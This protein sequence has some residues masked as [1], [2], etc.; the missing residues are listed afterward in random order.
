MSTIQQTVDKAGYELGYIEYGAAL[1]ATDAADAMQALNE[2][3]AEWEEEDLNFNWF[4]Q[5]AL[6]DTLPIP[7]WAERCVIL[8][9]AIVLSSRFNVAP[10]QSLV[11]NARKSMT[12]ISTR[13]INEKLRKANMN[14]LPTGNGWGSRYDIDTDSF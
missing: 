12:T 9:L 8:N 6:S 11:D 1:D 14:H 5:D 3:M 7:N 10:S 4:V 2:M 13:K